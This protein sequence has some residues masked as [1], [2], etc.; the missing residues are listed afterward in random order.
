VIVVVTTGL[1]AAT[2]RGDERGFPLFT[3]YSQNQFRAGSQTFGAA[4]DS[5]GLLHFANLTGVLTYDGA[6]WHVTHLPNES[7][8]FS[9]AADDKGRVAVG[10][11]SEIGYLTS[12]TSGEHYHSLIP[13]LPATV[14]DVGEVRSIA[15]TAQGFLFLGEHSL[16][17]WDG[18]SI[19]VIEDLHGLKDPPS[20]VYRAGGSLYLAGEG[21]LEAIDATT[22]RVTAID[23]HPVERV[24]DAGGERAMVVRRDGLFV[25][26]HGIFQPFAP[27]ALKWLAGKNI[28]D[29]R[30][31][32]DGRFV[33]AT[34]QDGL[35]ILDKSGEIDQIIDRAAG[36]PEYLLAAVLPD[37]EGS[38]WIAMYGPIARIDLA[39]PVSIL[40]SRSGLKGMVRDL[41][42]VDGH[43]MAVSSFGLFAF[44]RA[45]AHRIDAIPGPA[46]SLLPVGKV[47]IV[48]TSHGLFT[49][50][51]AGA[52]TPIAGT[53]RLVAYVMLRSKLDPSRVWLGM[54][55]GLGVLHLDGSSWR[56]E[57]TV[58]GIP[59]HIQSL[60]EE[61]SAV[62]CGTVFDG[63]IRVD[64]PFSAIPRATRFG[65]GEMNLTPIGGRILASAPGKGGILELKASGV[66]PDPLLGNIHPPSGF[67]RT[68]EDA[69]GNV[70]L[71][72]VP[73]RLIMR[74]PDGRY[75]SEGQP[76]VS[77][78]PA[79]IQYLKIDD[80]GVVWFGSDRG[81]YRYEPSTAQ[82]TF[83]QPP[84]MVRGVIVG[85]GTQANGRDGMS[86]AHAFRR[87][88]IDLAPASYRPGIL[89]QYR[90]DGLDSN[91]SQWT[92]ES[93]VDFT[94]LAEGDYTFRA[95]TRGP[96]GS[97][98]KEAHWS[99]T[100]LPPWY[101]TVWAFV[102]WLLAATSVV[103]LIVRIR[104]R[105]L[106]RHAEHLRRRVSDRTKELRST[107]EQLRDAQRAL[108]HKNERLEQ[109]N[110]RLERMSLVDELTGIANRRYFQRALS[111]E[112]D[113]ARMHEQP[114]ALILID[115]DHFKELNDTH[116]HPAGDACL[117]SIGTLL[118]D[119]I[120]RSGD[121][122]ARY[123]GEEFVILL[124]GMGEGEAVIVAEGVRQSIENA[125][126][127][128]DGEALHVTAS[129]GVAAMHPTE[130]ESHD[131]IIDRADRALYAAKHAGR[132]CVRFTAEPSHGTWLRE[133]SG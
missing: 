27:A 129:C 115:L 7:A 104:T 43:L 51:E 9:I 4:Q 128:A 45:I 28:T 46:W 114:L 106:S 84:P 79:D 52:V 30:Q 85:E 94:N 50:D 132:N 88:R 25:L 24:F 93:F 74:H 110:A 10:G 15:A 32:L 36:L 61:K 124:A 100:V 42:R 66:R 35:L 1:L 65:N 108:V 44:D 16:L 19:R 118:G 40:D 26:D 98:S 78:V 97:V 60:I 58:P 49:I 126:V 21:G 127:T 62:W 2:P 34:H 73:P 122:A 87:L 123:G 29:G 33:L 99:F 8:V 72:S 37:R 11:F 116:G 76:L 91:W 67:F 53:D 77:V 86:L 81:L 54:R 22:F 39:S 69:H 38:L 68:A 130:G 89:Y 20:G 105:T 103:L 5:R 47:L 23:P 117:R 80:D 55:S 83:V 3:I 75:D 31:L 90:L 6:S 71:N 82:P 95:R 112:W 13:L 18:R 48:G 107:V 131:V 17:F 57:R 59:T 12:D 121:V 92:E 119:R 111:E 109:A 101:R 133:T 120:R 113:R 56:F 14:R 70:W 63:V 64:E 41:V 125:S 96:A 102:L